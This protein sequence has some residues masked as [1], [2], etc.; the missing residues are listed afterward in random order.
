MVGVFMRRIKAIN[1]KYIQ[2]SDCD[3]DFLRQFRWSQD[4][5]GYF[6]C[7]QRGFW[8]REQINNKRVHWFVMKLAGLSC[9]GDIS[10]DHINRNPANNTLENLRFATRTSQ[11]WNTSLRKDNT[12]GLRGVHVYGNRWISKIHVNGQSKHIGI[13]DTKEESHIAYLEERVK[14]ERYEPPWSDLKLKRCIDLEVT[15]RVKSSRFVGV[16]KIGKGWRARIN[17]NRKS[18]HLGMFG[19]QKQAHKAHQ[20]AAL[21]FVLAK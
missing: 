12:S 5:K 16:T 11:C 18:I 8:L 6:N 3:Y 21:S 10:A 13:Y 20:V 9:P 15:R 1:G 17:V 7:S 4:S 14:L 19:T 2:V